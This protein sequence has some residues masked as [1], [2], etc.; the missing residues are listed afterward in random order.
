M[1]LINFGAAFRPLQISQAEAF[2][3]EPITRVIDL[4]INVDP[5]QEMLPQFKQRMVKLKLGNLDLRAEPVVV[6]L[7]QQNYLAVM[8][9]AELHARMGYFP[10]II[11]TRMKASGI[12]PYYEV[13]EVIDLQAIEDQ[14][15]L[16]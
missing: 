5:D 11:R 10:R 7:P 14:I 1:I 6:N 15:F 2:L 16:A 12:L 3:H 8:I 9:L 13:A 4:S